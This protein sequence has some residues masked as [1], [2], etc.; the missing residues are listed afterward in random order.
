[1]S[2]RLRALELLGRPATR[3]GTGKRRIVLFGD[4]HI[5]AIQDAL[6][7]RGPERGDVH[8]EARRLLKQKANAPHAR[9][10]PKAGTIGD[11]SFEDFLS[12]AATLRKTD[13]LVSVIGGNQHAVFGTIKHPLPFDFYSP[14]NPI[15]QKHVSLI[16]YRMLYD[17]FLRG[18]RKGDG[19]ML[20]ALRSATPARVVHL[21]APP[22]KQK[23]A[24]IE[25]YHDTHFA[26]EGIE[27]L[28][29]SSP[30]LR[31]KFWHLQNRVLQEICGELGIELIPPPAEAM[32]PH[33]F[34]K[35][36]CYAG[37]AT[38]ANIKYGE[39]VLADLERRFA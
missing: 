20:V 31:M 28:G 15:V 17:Q 22:P 19:T 14:E 27:R 34:L 9:S 16:P 2:L 21:L 37:D 10:S 36:S 33:G 38:H 1:M 7:L 6:K 39:L 13:V 8:I 29:V 12:V 23:N 32:D 30:A 4:S 35:R 3:M 25:L 24:F 18:L 5:H 11:T 26:A